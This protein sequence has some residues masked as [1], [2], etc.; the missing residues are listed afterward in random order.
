[1]KVALCLSGH[2]NNF[3]GARKQILDLVDG[4]NCDVFCYTSDMMSC[5]LALCKGKLWKEL[6]NK[7]KTIIKLVVPPKKECIS[8]GSKHAENDFYGYGWNVDKFV[9]E[10]FLKKT[11]GSSLKKCFVWEQYRKEINDNP[12]KF[13]WDHIRKNELYKI[14][15]CHKLMEKYEQEN[16]FK[17]D[18]VIRSRL[19]LQLKKMISLPFP[20]DKYIATLGGWPCPLSSNK[21]YFV[22]GFCYGDRESMRIFAELIEVK[23]SKKYTDKVYATSNG[24]GPCKGAYLEPIVS[25]YLADKDINI[26]YLT[27]GP[28]NNRPYKLIRGIPDYEKYKI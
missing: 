21:K 7:N 5:R 10:N 2:I 8:K 18:V 27:K 4:T 15:E 28:K 20:G 1:M 26:I 24:H 23:D 11:F 19:D 14:Y 17:Y 3:Y 16:N 12:L 25:H 9:L 13:K 6:K 22:P